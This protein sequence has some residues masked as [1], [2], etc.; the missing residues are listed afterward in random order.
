MAVRGVSLPTKVLNG[1]FRDYERLEKARG[2]ANKV[3][4]HSQNSSARFFFSFRGTVRFGGLNFIH[5]LLLFYSNYL[6]KN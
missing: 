1:I 3:L 6:K 2:L 5:E 4:R